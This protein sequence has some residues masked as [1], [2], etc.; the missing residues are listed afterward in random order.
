MVVKNN[1]K[2]AILSSVYPEDGGMGTV[3][4]SEIL[5]FIKNKNLEIKIFVP[6]YNKYF[7]KDLE[8]YTEFIKPVFKIGMGAF[9]PNIRKKIKDFDIIYLHYPAF[10]VAENLLFYKKRKDQK[11][12]IRYHMDLVNKNIFKKIFYKINKI[13]ILPKILKKADKVIF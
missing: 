7:S 9:C 5:N 3:F 4:I 12:I 6:N 1:K 11:I 8:K 10:G 2:I 13:F